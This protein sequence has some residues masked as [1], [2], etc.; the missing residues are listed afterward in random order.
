VCRSF[1]KTTTVSI[2]RANSNKAA[3]KATYRF[4]NNKKVTEKILI[5]ELTENCGKLCAGRNLLVIQDTF[6]LNHYGQRKRIKPGS[7]LGPVS[8]LP[9]LGF[10][11]HHG[12]VIDA[13]TGVPLGISSCQ[14]W[15]RE[16]DAPQKKE[17]AHTQLPIEEKESYKWIKC[18]K[19][20][21]EALQQA[22]HITFIED[23]EGDIY[24]QFA[25]VP[26]D[27][28]D[29]IIRCR[30]NRTLSDGKK[31]YE[32]LANQRVSGSY[33]LLLEGDHRSGK[34]KRRVPIEVRFAEVSISKPN[35][36]KNNDSLPPSIK[37]YAVEAREKTDK[38]NKNAII[39][40]L[41]TVKPV[42]TFEDAMQVIN[43]YKKRWYIEE[44]HRVVKKQGFNFEETQLE[45]GW[46]IRKLA[47]LIMRAALRTMQMWLAYEDEK[48]QN[49]D[50]VFTPSERT[51]LE[52]INE[53][54][55]GKTE[56]QKNPYP[57][58]KLTWA[59]WVIA[60]LGGWDGYASQRKPGPITISRGNQKFNEMYQ[61]WMLAKGF[62]EK[63]VGTR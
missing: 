37:L 12:L 39:W 53:Q 33:E 58:N 21:Q 40:R 57:K 17:G 49:I 4:L 36:K 48:G 30:E 47:V 3:T 6:S 18:C 28:T 19:E 56:K 22:A 23:R 20:S 46:V 24:E 2:R 9:G 63:D 59:T 60:R 50:E 25:M 35:F 8:Y 41:L 44:L 34:Q 13:D 14:M 29:L 11:I 26:D 27:K 43:K 1:E 15:N 52:Q 10:F 61:G 55:E 16:K 51:C 5:E 54:M 38:P 32:T 45:N 62:F 7:G 31:L 42:N